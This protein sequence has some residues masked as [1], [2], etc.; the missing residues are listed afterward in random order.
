[1]SR[2]LYILKPSSNPKE[3]H[4]ALLDYLFLVKVHEVD[5]KK[6]T[7]I[8]PFIRCQLTTRTH[9]TPCLCWNLTLRCGFPRIVKLWECSMQCKHLCKSPGAPERTT[10][11]AYNYSHAEHTSI[12]RTP[13]IWTVLLRLYKLGIIGT[14]QHGPVSACPWFGETF[15]WPFS[16]LNVESGAR[17][18][19]SKSNAN[20]TTFPPK[21][22]LRAQ[23]LHF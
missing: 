20:D 18:L 17:G 23:F 22:I 2:K 19:F 4:A 3:D 8:I 7:S 15:Q 12:W 11:T 1:M 14:G 10:K 6:K 13:W 16:F 21:Q 9:C 5:H